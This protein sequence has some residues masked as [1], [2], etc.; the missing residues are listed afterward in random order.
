MSFYKLIQFLKTYVDSEGVDTPIVSCSRTAQ[1]WLCKLGYEY[2][3]VH[4]DVFINRYE[5]PNI[6]ED[7]RVFLN[8]IKEL[9]PYIVEFD[10]NGAIKLKTYSSD[11]AIKGNYQ[12]S[13]IVIIYN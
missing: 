1:R 12:Q 13:I 8:K 11:C 6:V 5:Q 2:K 3:D 10:K 9:K 4:K 7:C